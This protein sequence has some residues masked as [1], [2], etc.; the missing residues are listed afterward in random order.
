MS[1]GG[2]GGVVSLFSKVAGQ[3]NEPVLKRYL[4]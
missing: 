4:F 1:A 2:G 3:Q